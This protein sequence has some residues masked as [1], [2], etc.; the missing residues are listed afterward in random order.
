MLMLRFQRCRRRHS[1]RCRACHVDR[2]ADAAITLDTL[3]FRY[4]HVA[5]DCCCWLLLPHYDYAITRHALMLRHDYCYHADTRYF[6]RHSPPL[7]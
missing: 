2:Y 5:A 7:R 6:S 1:R 4:G 3:S